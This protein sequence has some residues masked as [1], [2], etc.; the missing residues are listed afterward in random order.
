MANSFFFQVEFSVT[1][2][3]LEYRIHIELN[4]TFPRNCVTDNRGSE[5]VTRR[6]NGPIN[7]QTVH[8]RG[9]RAMSRAITVTKRRP[10][11]C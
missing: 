2:R 4:I 9:P 10:A 6:D 5:L 11:V 3:F 8:G 1:S 7:K